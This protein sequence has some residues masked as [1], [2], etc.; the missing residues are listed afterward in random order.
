MVYIP[1][2]RRDD[3]FVQGAR[4]GIQISIAAANRDLQ[5]R[6]L[7]QQAEDQERRAVALAQHRQAILE[8]NEKRIQ[9]TRDKLTSLDTKWKSKFIEGRV[10]SRKLLGQR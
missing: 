3:S 1:A 4:L 2:P 9:V 10:L 8:Q 5:R 7:Q 6:K